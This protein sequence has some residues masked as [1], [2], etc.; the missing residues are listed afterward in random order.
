[1]FLYVRRAFPAQLFV[2]ILHFAQDLFGHLLHPSLAP[3]FKRLEVF[4]ICFPPCPSVSTT[5]KYASNAALQSHYWSPIQRNLH[6][7]THLYHAKETKKLSRICLLLHTNRVSL[8]RRTEQC[9]PGGITIRCAT[10]MF[11]AVQ[12]T[13]RKQKD[14]LCISEQ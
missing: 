13:V 4:L 10:R 1:M 9:R 8:Y 6:Y 5:L 2:I 11:S 14:A 7:V 3:H 12:R